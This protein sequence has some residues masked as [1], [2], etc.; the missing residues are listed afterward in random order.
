MH[1]QINRL[2]DDPL[3]WLLEP[4]PAILGAQHPDGCWAKRG[5]GYSASYRATVW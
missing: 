1:T 4:V 3:P 5:G 2:A